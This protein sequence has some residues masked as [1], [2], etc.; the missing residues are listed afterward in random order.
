[1][2]ALDHLTKNEFPRSAHY[3]ARWL[4]ELDMGPHPLWLLED[5]AG[6][7]DLRPGMRVLDLGSGRGATSVFLAKEYGVNVVAADLWVEPSE[8]TAVFAKEGVGDQVLAMRVDAHRLPFG[9]ASFDVIV[10]VDAWEYFGTGDHY[11]PYLASF[12]RP[13][14]Q[15]GVATPALTTEV[16]ELGEIPEHIDQVVGAETAAWHTPGWLRAQWEF[17]R[18]FRHVTA[19]AQVDG[20]AN[21]LLWERAVL[22][23]KGATGSPVQNMLETDGGAFVT[24]AMITGRV[25]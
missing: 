1:M 18:A 23:L 20:C 7:L 22:E 10:S 8:A 9:R 3:D 24:F 16:R 19:R 5:L 12:L 6:D 21:W 11:P 25:T 14:G 17:G 2:P 4:V 15:L 13:G